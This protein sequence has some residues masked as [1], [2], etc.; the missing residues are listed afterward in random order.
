MINAIRKFKIFS[1]DTPKNLKAF[2]FVNLF[3]FMATALSGIFV[4]ILLFKVNN[5]ISVVV[6]YNMELFFLTVFAFYLAG[7]MAKKVAI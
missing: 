3:Y 4:N 7:F 6:K 1:E 2:W 5:S